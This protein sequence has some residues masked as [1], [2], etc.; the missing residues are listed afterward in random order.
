MNELQPYG[1]N[2][3]VPGLYQPG[4]ADQ[5]PPTQTI[6]IAGPGLK[7]DYAGLLEYWQMVRRHKAAVVVAIF[8]GGLG[9]FLVTLSSPRVYQARTS[10][11][12]QGLNEEFLNMKSVNPNSDPT[13][14]YGSDIQTQVKILQ[15]RAL[16]DRVRA[17]VE[18]E[19]RP[20]NLQPP[21]RLGLWRKT[22]NINP[23]TEESIWV[24]ALG[25]AA[26]S[27][28]VRGSETNRIVEL[29]CDSTHPQLAADFCNT[30]TKEYIDQNLEARWKS[31]EYTGEWLTKQLQDLKVKLE[32][33]GEELQNYARAT[34]L[35][36]T[37][38]GENRA[39]VN[40]TRLSDLQKELSLAQADRFSKQSKS[41]MAANSPASALPDVLDDPT[42]KD[43]QRA[44]ADLEAK[45]AQLGVSF[46]PNAPE[47][48][49][50]QVQIDALQASLANARTNVLTRIRQD[51]EAAQ[52]REALLTDAYQDQAHLVSGKAE[53]IAHFN[54]MKRD[55]DATRM[56]YETLQQRLKEASIASALRA[57]NSRVVD[58]ATVPTAPYAPNVTQRAMLGLLFGAVLG[59]TFSVMKER[60]DR[61]LQD[62]GDVSY[63][64]GIPELGVV[65]V[66]EMTAVPRP[67]RLKTT[68]AIALKGEDADGPASKRPKLELISWDQKTSLLAESFRTTL[69]SILFSRKGGER[70]RV[71]VLT[72][73]SPKEGKTTVVS[74]LGIALAE[75]NHRVLLID[76]DMRRPR[77]HNVFDVGNHHGLSD[78]LMEKTPLTVEALQ[79]A[80][81]ATV[82]P[83]LFILPS[84]GSRRNVS[85]LLHSER[86][87]ELLRIARAAFDTVVIDTPP[88]VNIADA[89]VM[90][91]LA[92]GLIMVVRSGVTTRDAA[93]LAKARFA[94]DGITMLGTILN[95][96]NPKTPGYSYYRYYYSGY[97]HY[98]GDGSGKNGGADDGNDDEDGDRPERS[99]RAPSSQWKPGFAFGA[100]LR[101]DHASTDS[102]S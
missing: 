7:R 51:F 82:V 83:G 64:L 60:A 61:T 6:D 96:W 86:L 102:K 40:E 93:L 32:K 26:G 35:V 59:V 42:L 90:G 24:Q 25:T 21:D 101:D 58:N 17:K 39:D 22:L 85:S 29:T 67:K 30:L 31:T 47:V 2:S 55:V 49:K 76:A 62:P 88:M 3:S 15:S 87:S 9:G 80:A 19:P 36:I 84:G 38:D 13:A 52:R 99:N 92:D 79:E 74:N 20:A 63:Y 70:P 4:P 11:E 81:V 68:A 18:A 89:R 37:G 43:T 14:S 16:N 28:R 1:P 27:V 97:L 95:G 48:K 23:P 33:Q 34:S 65:P 77:L 72:S 78:L 45:L 44:L 53:A 10:L 73:A 41:E 50:V 46:T 94:E 12:I 71:L 8:V 75:I 69:T 56:L 54:L 57:N 100:Q 98:Y 5:Y 91:R 66:G